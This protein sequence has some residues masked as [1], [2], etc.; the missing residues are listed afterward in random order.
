M[1][2]VWRV[3]RDPFYSFIYACKCVLHYHYDTMAQRMEQADR[4]LVNTF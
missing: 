2:N 4:V 3:R 1:R